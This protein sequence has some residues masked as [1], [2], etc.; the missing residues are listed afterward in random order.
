M[1]KRLRLKT[2]GLAKEVL[3]P[4]EVNP[5]AKTMVC[6]FGST[7][8][9]MREACAAADGT[10]FIHYPQGWPF[11]EDATLAALKG[12][13]RVLTVENNATGQ[14]ARLTRKETGTQ[15]SGSVLKFYGRP[16]TADEVTAA[17]EGGK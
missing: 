17:L 11:P 14:L 3:P 6:G 1:E 9:V 12:A 4:T 13:G 7:L 10:G 5:G 8:G 16:F 2:A 15:V